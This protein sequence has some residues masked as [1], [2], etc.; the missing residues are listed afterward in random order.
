[1]ERG[2]SMRKLQGLKPTT[3][4]ERQHHGTFLHSIGCAAG[5]THGEAPHLWITRVMRLSDHLVHPVTWNLGL[6]RRR[7]GQGILTQDQIVRGDRD[8]AV[9]DVTHYACGRTYTL[10]RALSVDY[11][12]IGRHC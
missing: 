7:Y 9:F 11:P 5:Y 8:P 6:D 4:T 2:R 12:Q 1:M 10:L 3:I